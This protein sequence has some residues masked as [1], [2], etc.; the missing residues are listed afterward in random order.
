MDLFVTGILLGFFLSF[1]IGPVFFILIETSITKGFKAALT[2]DAGVIIADICFILIA[3]FSS[4]QLINS[5]KDDPALFLF[6]GMIMIT[7]GIISFV[8]L[9]KL[10]KAEI[11]IEATSYK[12]NYFS[13]FAKGFL[14][15]FI[16]VGVLGFWLTIIITIGPQLEMNHGRMINFFAFVIGAYLLTDIFKML[17]AK[18]LQSKLTPKNIL[19]VKKI[20]CVL[21]VIFGLVIMSKS[22]IKSEIKIPKTIKEHQFQ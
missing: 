8:R 5:I 1:M 15:N 14:L 17:L 20:S 2:F 4:F 12:N 22:F 11:H 13:L 21:L 16:N 18:Q 6:G 9:Q 7:Y 19:K 10:K 3:Y